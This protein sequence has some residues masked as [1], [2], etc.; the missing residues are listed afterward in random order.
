MDNGEDD[1]RV[2]DEMQDVKAAPQADV[3][4]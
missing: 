3:R 2:T 4:V 1:T